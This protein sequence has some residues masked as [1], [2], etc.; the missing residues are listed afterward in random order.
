M[1]KETLL[2]SLRRFPGDPAMI[3]R[4]GHELET[5]SE[6]QLMLDVLEQ[7]LPYVKQGT[8]G[9]AQVTY[10]LAKASVEL[11]I[12]R[13]A[14]ALIGRSLLIRPD[15]AFSHHIKGRA[16]AGMQRFAEAIAAQQRCV[17]LAPDFCWGW[18]EFGRL[19]RHQGKLSDASGS[20]K[21]ALELQPVQARHHHHLMREALEEVKTQ[22]GQQERQEAALSLWPERPLPREGERLSSLDELELQLEQFNLFLNKIERKPNREKT[23]LNEP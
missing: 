4:L 7:Q 11:G 18:F 13:R 22:L 14:L 5:S 23:E 3:Q 19:Q 20:L 16:L 17:Q 1:L 6:W 8:P 9:E 21:R 15:F 10:L 2:E 12:E